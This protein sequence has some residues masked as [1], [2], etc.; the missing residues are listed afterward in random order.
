MF[1]KANS[2]F[3]LLAVGLY[4]TLSSGAGAQSLT[5]VGTGDGLDMLRAVAAVY[6]AEKGGDV[7]FP[8][9]IGSGGGIAAVAAGSERLARVARPLKETERAAGLIAIPIAQLPT[10]IIVHPGVGV[11]ALTS[12]Q[13]VSIFRGEITDWS[14]V[15]GKPGKIKVVRREEANS[16]LQV[17][18]A[19][20]PGWK[21]LQ[22]TTLSKTAVTTQDAIETVD[23]VEGS[24]GF[25]PYST[26]LLPD[27]IVL[28]IDGRAP[29]DEGY[30][31]AA[32]LQ[33]VYRGE[34]APE[35]REFVAFVRSNEGFRLLEAYGAVPAK[36]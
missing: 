6:R 22:I 9:S 33:F 10:A 28:R 20:M 7:I 8:A 3:P 16:S 15:G 2:S 12:E 36:D 27:A 24:I 18:R 31:S 35:A 21:D 29:T 25:V 32:L 14:A 23:R 26:S 1:R 11:S 30:P 17:L 19:S 34:I 13:L 5:V 4:M